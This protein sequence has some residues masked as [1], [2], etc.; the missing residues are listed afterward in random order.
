MTGRLCDGVAAHNQKQVNQSR[1]Y[2]EGAEYRWSGSPLAVPITDNPHAPTS[3]SA[4]AW[5]AGWNDANINAV[6][7]CCAGYLRTAPVGGQVSQDEY[8]DRMRARGYDVLRT[9]TGKTLFSRPEWPRPFRLTWQQ[10]TSGRVQD[11]L[12]PELPASEKVEFTV[13]SN[14]SLEP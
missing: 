4:N 5:D 6:E 1:A 14:D 11:Y 7:P 12:P 8:E 10:I 3:E 9:Q 2:C 13:D